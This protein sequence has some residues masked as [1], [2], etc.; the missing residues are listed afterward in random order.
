M[1]DKSLVGAPGGVMD[2][3]QA[4]DLRKRD[5]GCVAIAGLTGEILDLWQMKELGERRAGKWAGRETVEFG[6]LSRGWRLTIKKHVTT[7]VPYLSR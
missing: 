1:T 5:F 3:W 2:V 7:K 6:T 4:K